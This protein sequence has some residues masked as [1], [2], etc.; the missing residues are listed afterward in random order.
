MKSSPSV[1]VH[2]LPILHEACLDENDMKLYYLIVS[3]TSGADTHENAKG[4]ASPMHR[5]QV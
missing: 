4:H 5:L 2:G 1:E 3:D